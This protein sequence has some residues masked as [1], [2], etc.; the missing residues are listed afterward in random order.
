MSVPETSKEK[1]TTTTPATPAAV[2]S[3]AV[4]AKKEKTTSVAHVSMY[5]DEDIAAAEKFGRISDDGTIYVVD[6]GKDR[7]LGSI[8]EGDVAESAMKLYARRYL[9]LKQRIALFAQRLSSKNIKTHEIDSSLSAIDAELAAGKCIG[10]LAALRSRMSE[11][12]SQAAAKKKELAEAHQKAVAKAIADRTIVVEKAEAIVD[13][14]GS[15]TN[16]KDTAEKLRGLFDQWQTLQRTEARVDKPTADGLWKRFSSARSEFNRRRRT[17]AKNRDAQRAQARQNKEAII[18]EAESLKNSTQWGET[19]RAFNQLMDQWKAAGRAGHKDDDELWTRFR[20]AADVF[21][22]AREN[23][24]KAIDI[25][26]KDNLKKKEALLEQAEKL[27]PVPDE[28]AAKAA[29][30]KLNGI[31]DEWDQIGRVPR[32][33]LRRV[34]DRLSAV[35]NQI[36]AVEEAAWK[37]KDPETTA[38]KSSFENQITA[39]LKEIDMQIAAT[40]DESLKKKLEEEKKAKQQWLAAISFAR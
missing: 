5:T 6:D 2:P 24:R 9:D 8:A 34:E 3:P 13:Q 22:N 30:Q 40:D 10:D 20:S 29:R 7:A 4:L 32:E 27:V 1:P 37:A 11:L 21:F 31:M 28:K 33:D 18:A 12:E 16:W 25:E 36:K 26:E 19:S 23:D 17:W 15:D 38:R 14:L 35:E 39:R